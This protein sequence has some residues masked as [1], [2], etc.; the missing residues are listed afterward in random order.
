M[1]T[2]QLV[3]EQ[4]LN[5]LLLFHVLIEFITCDAHV[6][7]ILWSTLFQCTHLEDKH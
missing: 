6:M 4:K 7:L 3:D 2:L 5:V 1:D